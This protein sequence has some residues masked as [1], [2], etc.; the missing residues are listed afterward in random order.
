M[1]AEGSTNIKKS[2]IMRHIASMV[3]LR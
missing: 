1:F 2:A 3:G